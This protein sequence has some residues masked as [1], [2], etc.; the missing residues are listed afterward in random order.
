MKKFLAVLMAALMLF[1][2][3]T[4][5]AFAADVEDPS[6]AESEVVTEPAETYN[7]YE[8]CQDP[9][10][11]NILYMDKGNDV[12]TILHPGDQITT[13][14]N[15]KSSTKIDYYP[16]A[17]AITVKGWTPTDTNNLAFSASGAVKF[18]DEFNKN[19]VVVVKDIDFTDFTIAYSDENVFVGWVVKEYDSQANTITVYGVW[20]KG[21]TL[22]APD[23]SDDFYYIVDFFY[24]LRKSLS[25]SFL[26]PIFTKIR[27]LSNAFLAVVRSL[28]DEIFNPET[29]VAD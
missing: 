3:S 25:D 24:T 26:V 5:V 23:E 28:Y 6:E 16:D 4:L 19:E 11:A 12:A 27:E 17:D 1:T 7:S 14:K 22:P 2:G 29:V 8:I 10:F 18:R 13:Y 9:D 21:H 15:D 20:Q